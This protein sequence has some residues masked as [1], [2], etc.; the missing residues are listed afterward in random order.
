MLPLVSLQPSKEIPFINVEIAK[1]SDFSPAENGCKPQPDYPV[2]ALK[3]KILAA[4]QEYGICDNH[5]NPT[6]EYAKVLFPSLS[7]ENPEDSKIIE[8]FKQFIK[9]KRISKGSLLEIK[10]EFSFQD[11]F[12]CLLKKDDQFTFSIEE[13]ELH[14]KYLVEIAGMTCFIKLFKAI[15]PSIPDEKV[16]EWFQSNHIKFFFE[17]KA[18]AIELRFMNQGPLDFQKH[19]SNKLFHFLKEGMQN[20]DPRI[21]CE[22][23]KL[24][25]KINYQSLDP[26]NYLVKQ[27]ALLEFGGITK[28]K[29]VDTKSNQYVIFGKQTDDRPFETIFVGKKENSSS[30]AMESLCRSS[31]DCFTASLFSFLKSGQTTLS[32]HTGSFSPAK[33]LIDL[34]TNSYSVIEFKADGW[35]HYLRNYQRLTV[36][37]VEGKLIAF[38]LKDQ[39]PE[40]AGPYLFSMFEEEFKKIHLKEDPQ[41]AFQ[42][43]LRA[44]ISLFENYPFEFSE[45]V[46]GDLWQA[47]DKGSYL[48]FD[49]SN[50][51]H[52]LGIALK[53]GL[54]E[55]KLPFKLAYAWIGLIG[56]LLCP[57]SL[58][59][60]G[61]PEN[62]AM[63]AH[64]F[65]LEFPFLMRIKAAPQLSCREVFSALKEYPEHLPALLEIYSSLAF[66]F[67]NFVYPSPLSSCLSVLKIDVGYLASEAIQW[68]KH[69]DPIVKALGLQLFLL[70]PQSTQAQ[71][72]QLC[73]S[74]PDILKNKKEKEE[75]L[76][77]LE[78]YLDCSPAHKEV[79]KVIRK[80]AYPSPIAYM[81]ALIETND[82]SVIQFAHRFWKTEEGGI[83]TGWLIFKAL[84]VHDSERALSH[85]QSIKHLLSTEEQFE[86]FH[87]LSKQTDCSSLY[88]F[89]IESAAILK[90]KN[91]KQELTEC[92]LPS[93]QDF[94]IHSPSSGEPL[95]LQVSENE[96]LKPAMQDDLWL[97]VLESKL[98]SSAHSTAALYYTLIEKKFIPGLHSKN[99]K[100]QEFKIKLGTSL[101]KQKEH[102]LSQKFLAELILSPLE[103][104]LI[105]PLYDYLAAFLKEEVI[106]F[107]EEYLPLIGHLIFITPSTETKRSIE[108][109]RLLCGQNLPPLLLPSIDRLLSDPRTVEAL[110]SSKDS[111][112]MVLDYAEKTLILLPRDLWKV[113]EIIKNLEGYPSDNLQILTFAAKL[114]QKG[115]GLNIKLPKSILEWLKEKHSNIL[116]FLIMNN[117]FEEVYYYIKVVHTHQVNNGT[118][119]PITPICQHFLQT[120][121]NSFEKLWT[122]FNSF[123]EEALAAASFASLHPYIQQ[124]L[125]QKEIKYLLHAAEQI[126]KLQALAS[127]ENEVELNDQLLFS[128]LDRLIEVDCAPQAL[129]LLAHTCRPGSSV[130]FCSYWVNLTTILQ[131]ISSPEIK[132]FIFLSP[133]AKELFS[134]RSYLLRELAKKEIEERLNAKAFNAESLEVLYDFFAFYGIYDTSLWLQFLSTLESHAPLNI[135]EKCAKL[136]QESEFHGLLKDSCWVHY[137][138]LLR[139]TPADLFPHLSLF[140]SKFKCEEE[141]KEA[142]H[143]IFLHEILKLSNQNFDEKK[144]S[145]LIQEKEKLLSTKRW[146]SLDLAW[147]K[148]LILQLQNANQEKCL[149]ILCSHLMIQLSQFDKNK[150]ALSFLPKITEKVFQQACRL[151]LEDEL[152][153]FLEIISTQ[154]NYPADSLLQ[155]VAC[156]KKPAPCLSHLIIPLMH[157][158]LKNGS[159]QH[160]DLL[161][162]PFTTLFPSALSGTTAD[163][164]LEGE[165]LLIVAFQTL[166]L[167]TN[168]KAILA[169]AIIARSFQLHS[170]NIRKAIKTY[171]LWA[172]SLF[173]QPQ[174]LEAHIKK[175]VGMTL[176]YTKGPEKCLDKFTACFK[177]IMDVKGRAK[178]YS[179]KPLFNNSAYMR[180]CIQSWKENHCS[181]F[182]MEA[183]HGYCMGNIQDYLN[184]KG[185]ATSHS[186]LEELEEIIF[187]WPL[188]PKMPISVTHFYDDAD[189][190]FIDVNWQQDLKELVDAADKAEVFNDGTAKKYLEFC[191]YLNVENKVLTELSL[192]HMIATEL[193]KKMIAFNSPSAIVRAID[194]L[195][196]WNGATQPAQWKAWAS[197]IECIAKACRKFPLAATDERTLLTIL[198]YATI[199]HFNPDECAAPTLSHLKKIANFIF[200]AAWTVYKQ[201]NKE[202]TLQYSLHYISLCSLVLI[203][204]LAFQ[205]KKRDL[206]PYIAH[207]RNMIP[208][209]IELK[210]RKD[211]SN[212]QLIISSTQ[213]NLSKIFCLLFK[214]ME[215]PQSE[216]ERKM[217]ET[218]VIDWLN[219][220][221]E[222][223]SERESKIASKTIGYTLTQIITQIIPSPIFS[224]QHA[225]SVNCFEK[226]M[227]WMP[228]FCR[229]DEIISLEYLK[230]VFYS[231]KLKQDYSAYLNRV[232]KGAILSLSP[233][234]FSKKA[235]KKFGSLLLFLPQNA[236]DEQIKLR[237]SIF[238]DFL[239]K[240]RI[241]L[242]DLPHGADLSV[243]IALGNLLK[244]AIL[245]EL[246]NEEFPLL[247]EWKEILKEVGISLKEG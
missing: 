11:I 117:C 194:L 225:P 161:T 197:N 156:L 2:F 143:L 166:N 62:V 110:K 61:V 246:F 113:Y 151:H 141:E 235:F 54:K 58:T 93:F 70:A 162:T 167:K 29:I 102:A 77:A 174:L 23:L 177:K 39:S 131:P 133:A 42:Y 199:E 10:N 211:E 8:A 13:I 178:N 160:L 132:N 184:K 100:F 53:K 171:I 200:E 59:R 247:D 189:P 84:A 37:E 204:H 179:Q 108:I 83:I 146:P 154:R 72:D 60:L 95:L 157:S 107:K 196:R 181:P 63:P 86:G 119:L 142:Y 229:E 242:K 216:N 22:Q 31:L 73:F 105:L 186:I 123:P 35:L 231:T 241:A 17:Q 92:L 75:W 214:A 206:N 221:M 21:C 18:H 20:F 207:I 52:A 130:L 46:I 239:Q 79:L 139:K 85:Y 98:D 183:L 91:K 57:Q 224:F 155:I 43:L 4:L 78:L 50:Q 215:D 76:Q 101:L 176:I 114:F 80:E 209:I 56:F 134:T 124:L 128:C 137:L 217:Q 90:N 126:K 94:I 45:Q 185:H 3:D 237:N 64:A 240:A 33:T 106:D 15:F 234:I 180:L 243:K 118:K 236:S 121:E 145:H 138:K 198:Y 201:K 208:V 48:N 89:L 149:K 5:F 97:A 147:E 66:N 227:Q 16:Q 202:F 1:S 193:I 65:C 36:Q 144:Y 187:C 25:G 27:Y 192:I 212:D 205:G 68:V 244:E 169:D 218:L 115:E 129:D 96:L 170:D 47:M 213:Q 67:E 210:T 74:L 9:I 69:K 120:K 195:N 12:T 49:S 104:M 51:A 223:K 111:R 34:I 26:S 109:I 87:L 165:E 190:D 173:V 175:A 219:S 44:S 82:K 163:A 158:I 122:L 182:L 188:P 222:V 14:G 203:K 140:P 88:H 159:I 99:S 103:P 191:I 116:P 19:L 152:T 40:S 28:R 233:E 168:Q 228:P 135:I 125:S 153:S 38:L 112:K 164:F 127:G 136:F 71:L 41:L 148:A 238:A 172:P 24:S 230:V 220:L 245:L 32:V 55:N 226:A 150:D 7:A 6:P 232:M 81:Q 30:S